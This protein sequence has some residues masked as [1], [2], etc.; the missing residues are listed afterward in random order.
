MSSRPLVKMWEEKDLVTVSGLPV[1]RLL[2][3][4][5]SETD[6]VSRKFFA[7]ALDDV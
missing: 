7:V 6:P 1:S 5:N 2:T 3:D 4:P